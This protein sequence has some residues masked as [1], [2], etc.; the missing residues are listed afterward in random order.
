MVKLLHGEMAGHAARSVG[1]CRQSNIKDP[2]A[3]KP[4]PK[5]LAAK[6]RK[7]RRMV[8]AS[9]PLR[10]MRLFAA[11]LFGSGAAALVEFVLLS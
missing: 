6:R 4:Q 1:S 11:I 2:S 5:K 7:R 3:A 10:L 9:A 8:Y